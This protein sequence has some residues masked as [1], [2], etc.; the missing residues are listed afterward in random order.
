M[1]IVAIDTGRQWGGVSEMIGAEQH[2]P[3]ELLVILYPKVGLLNSDWARYLKVMSESI[4]KIIKKGV[5]LNDYQ[6]D[7]LCCLSLNSQ[8]VTQLI[9]IANAHDSPF[10]D[11]FSMAKIRTN[12]I[13]SF[14]KISDDSDGCVLLISKGVIP[15]LKQWF[16]TED[17]ASIE[18]AD[19]AL[20][21]SRLSKNPEGL[22][23][24]ND[25]D[26]IK[27]LMQF[28]FFLYSPKSE[29]R[30]SKTRVHVVMTVGRLATKFDA[31]RYLIS[32]NLVSFL[33]QS[34]NLPHT[35]GE[36]HALLF[37]IERLSENPNQYGLEGLISQDIL[38]RLF[39]C[40]KLEN[41][42]F[43]QYVQILGIIGTIANLYSGRC[44]LIEQNIK[45][46]L[47]ALIHRF[48]HHPRA[49]DNILL[50][51]VGISSEFKLVTSNTRAF[52]DAIIE[53]G[54]IDCLHEYI[55]SN[56]HTQERR[57][58]ISLVLGRIAQYPELIVAGWYEA[59][60]LCLI[61]WA[62]LPDNTPY[63]LDQ[64]VWAISKIFKNMKEKTRF[65]NRDFIQS[66]IQ[67]IELPDLSTQ[68]S[69]HIAFII[70]EVA[71][72][73][74]K[75]D[76]LIEFLPRLM[77]GIKSSHSRQRYN[78]ETD[79]FIAISECLSYWGPSLHEC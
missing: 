18:C 42:R 71:E 8:F 32:C 40:A 54:V 64:I 31:S 75:R 33:I 6:L 35:S 36:R 26:I 1:C 10:S 29:A 12:L 68:S 37:A 4:P 62:K 48:N 5:L 53:L 60:L 65:I 74:K 21:F 15:I 57:G 67:I 41:V 22:N 79:I 11:R 24:L 9:Q 30:D 61:D 27:K 78:W 46:D 72:Q 39:E 56:H 66:M 55:C 49:F 20:I 70:R 76:I 44:A 50:I 7:I 69:N 3:N 16:L 45:N 38:K 34:I 77:L 51:F 63:I 25:Q 47:R 17:N 73:P 2:F 52:L 58:R 19:I 23:A 14:L 43:E 13:C 59:F 28:S